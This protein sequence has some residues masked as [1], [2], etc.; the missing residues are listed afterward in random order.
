MKQKLLFILLLSISFINAQTEASTSMGA[1]YENQVFYSL[2]TQSATAYP[3]NSWDIAFLRTSNFDLAVRVN[4]GIG[5][6]VF[7]ASNNPENWDAIN[8]TEESQWTV[9]RNSEISWTN[10]AFMQGSASYGFG[11]YNPSTHKV[12]GTV[13]FV[14]KY[15]DGTYRKFFIEEYYGGY[16]FKYST[17]D[18]QAWGDDQTATVSNSSNPDNIF[19]YYSLQNNQEVV[20]EP[21]SNAWHLKFTRYLTDYFGDGS[22]FYPVTGVLTH[23]SLTVAKTES[24]DTSNLEYSD[25]IN[26][27]GYDWKSFTGSGYTV[28]SDMSYY[29]KDAN[30]VVYKINFTSFSGSGSGDLSFNFEDVTAS[31]SI[32]S[33]TKDV[34]FGVYPNPTTDKRVNL[35]YDVNTLNATNNT[36]QIYSTAGQKVYSADLKNASG[37]YNKELDLSRL[38]SGIYMLQFTSGNTL[39]TKKLILN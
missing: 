28:N 38:S 15:G 26:T 3:A 36:V 7:E 2:T 17:W 23:P 27:I 4:A 29:V 24:D 12:T 34:T 1:G 25:K 19:N 9:L 22:T 16:T 35:L 21:A 10:G 18:G 39:I 14:L 13:I 11:E 33:V 32:E 8:V 37:F 6:E 5:I 30:D 20:V 31:L